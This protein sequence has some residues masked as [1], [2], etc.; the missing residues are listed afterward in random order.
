MEGM[1]VTVRLTGGAVLHGPL[2]VDAG[3]AVPRSF[4]DL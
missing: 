4:I 3:S 1:I 2:A